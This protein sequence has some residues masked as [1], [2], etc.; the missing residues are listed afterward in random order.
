MAEQTASRRHGPDRRPGRRRRRSLPWL[1][2]YT[3]GR[4]GISPR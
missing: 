3:V 4:L 2:M 1:V